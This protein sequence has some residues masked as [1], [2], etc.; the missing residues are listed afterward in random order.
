MRKRLANRASW[1]VLLTVCVAGVWYLLAYLLVASHDPLATSKLPYPHLVIERLV[2]FWPTI[3]EATWATLS[4]ALLGFAIGGALGIVFGVLLVQ[5]RWIEV[6]V[7]PYMLVAQMIPMLALVPIIQAI[8]RKDDLTRL[9]IAALIT[10]FSVTLATLRGLKTPDR[11]AWDLLRSYGAGRAKGLRYL[12]LPSSL[13]FLFSGLK[14]AA[15]LSLVG[16]V[17]VDLLGASTGLGF[18]MLSALTF[19]PEQATMLWV[20]MIVTLLLGLL[21]ARAV[22]LVEHLVSP[23]QLAF[24][25]E[26]P[27]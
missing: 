11:L 16:A 15:P 18:L 5:A 19:G 14:I 3:A 22:A 8:T 26:G 12:Q 20:A 1:Y 23:W 10:F 7:M 25:S 27:R 6:S 13:P 4:R 24:R 17:I 2:D 9:A 21:L